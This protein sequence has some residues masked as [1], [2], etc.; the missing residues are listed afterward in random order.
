M[1]SNYLTLYLNS[2][3]A[4]AKTLTIKSE[5][6]AKLANA[7]I[8]K[9]GGTVNQGDPRTWK[10][11][12]NVCGEYHASDTVMEVI[13]LDTLQP[14]VFNKHNL[15]IHP[16]TAQGYRYG[17]R[18]Y[19]E[20]LARFPTQE[21]LILGVLYPATMDHAV[22]APDYSVLAYDLTAVESNED[23][24]IHQLNEYCVNYGARWRN[25]AF[26]I[27]HELYDLSF[28]NVLYHQLPIAILQFRDD[29]RNTPQAHSFHVR[30]HL[31]S[32][33]GLDEFLPYLTQ[34]QAM[35]LYRNI[36]YLETN[37]GQ[38][39]TFRELIEEVLTV[40]GIPLLGYDVVQRSSALLAGESKPG[41]GFE[42]HSMNTVTKAGEIIDPGVMQMKLS[43]KA[44]GNP[45]YDLRNPEELM[46]IGYALQN[47]F[48]TKVLESTMIEITEG[49]SVSAVEQAM[50]LWVFAAC[51]NRFNVFTRLNHPVTGVE[52]TL[53]ALDAYYVFLYAF[54]QA[55]SGGMPLLPLLYASRAPVW[56]IPTLT[57]LSGL[58]IPDKLPEDYPSKM[59]AAMITERSFLNLNQFQDA[60]EEMGTALDK[61]Q[62]YSAWPSESE[63]KMSALLMVEAFWSEFTYERPETGRP[64][65]EYFVERDLDFGVLEPEQW[66]AMYML[67]FKDITG[68]DLETTASSSNV[69]KAMIEIMRRLTSYSVMYVS[70]NTATSVRTMN[71]SNLLVEETLTSSGTYYE[72]LILPFEGAEVPK[73]VDLLFELL[74]PNLV[75]PG[76]ESTAMPVVD[77][78]DG[79]FLEAVSE[80]SSSDFDVLVH[81]VCPVAIN[82]QGEEDPTYIPGHAETMATL[83]PFYQVPNA[84]NY[85][86]WP[87]PP[88]PEA[89]DPNDWVTI[90]RLPIV[91]AVN[92]GN[93][94]L[95]DLKP[96]SAPQR[97]R[98]FGNEEETIVLNGIWPSH[99]ESELEAYKYTGGN[100][101][102]TSFTYTYYFDAADV[103]SWTGSI[104]N[105][106]LHGFNPVDGR[107]DVIELKKFDAQADTVQF[108]L[109]PNTNPIRI[110]LDFEPSTSGVFTWRYRPKVE[111]CVF[112]LD[113]LYDRFAI[114]AFGNA[115]AHIVMAFQ[116]DTG[117]IDLGPLQSFPMPV[118]INAFTSK[119]DMYEM[120]EWDTRVDR[121]DIGRL[122]GY[123]IQILS[124]IV[125]APRI[126]DVGTPPGVK[127]EPLNE[128]HELTAM[129]IDTPDAARGTNNLQME[130]VFDIIDLGN[131]ADHM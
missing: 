45:D 109:E 58:V 5:Y 34:K 16:A 65:V 111:T 17:T 37:A 112:S 96:F 21:Q 38:E 53:N 2:V 122:R 69:Q 30:M 92:N 79:A 51:T 1:S 95:G 50:G 105:Q 103:I 97:L 87:R 128:R 117:E 9:R 26:N 24:L 60:I 74:L 33:H 66:Q 52:M 46:D 31:A 94:Y 106:T 129:R 121:H 56:P 39:A 67:L 116:Q 76:Y 42:P 114:P 100:T 82:E 36:A 72:V 93:V 68:M 11:Y 19:K 104:G 84:W 102:V 113:K 35:W 81:H 20:L 59:R 131:M 15:A 25:G 124:G 64:T 4:L 22:S 61:H 7:D 40:R 63:A 130:P 110:E 98:Y 27:G 57:Q 80:D 10:Y 125:P 14:I 77:I 47:R 13:S 78:L 41:V 48:P 44:A 88:M 6:S 91:K 3:F 107:K 90:N 120:I 99:G 101:L 54:S 85:N 43:A 12:L 55:H 70:P 8:I 71:Y 126:I 62:Y 89:L 118:D 75:H 29:A 123:D 23:D 18:Y 119:T 49:S 32:H 73:P 83:L 115:Q 86:C 108:G 127:F 28:N